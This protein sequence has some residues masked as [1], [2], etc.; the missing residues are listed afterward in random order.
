MKVI[1][2]WVS[3]LGHPFVTSMVMV[4]AVA[5]RNSSAADALR[6]ALLVAA[7]AVV[8]IAV[9]MVRQVR[10]GA[11]GNVDASNPAERPL[12]FGV[13]IA[14]LA[15]LI[16][17]VLVLRPG[18]VLIRGALGVLILLIASAV[19][20]RWVKISLHSAFGAL[21]TTTLLAI[22]S[23]AGLVLLALLPALAWSR[24]SL[25]RHQ[26]IEVAIGLCLGV[27]IGLAITSL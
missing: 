14:A 11:W 16:A 23:P 2:K 19:A 12:L 6:T 15:L 4:L 27:V 3:I 8:P 24:L 21:A 17:M 25:E 26:G 22:R 20:T 18:S 5:L 10:K 1:A 7:I 13:S 9:L